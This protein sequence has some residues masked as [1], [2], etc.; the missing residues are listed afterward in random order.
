MQSA[1][2]QDS[3]TWS[4]V[5]CAAVYPSE[6][7]VVVTGITASES[8]PV[9]QHRIATGRRTRQQPSGIDD[10]FVNNTSVESSNG[11]PIGLSCSPR[12]RMTAYAARVCEYWNNV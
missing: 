9:A 2:D 10:V 5:W 6:E 8:S 7:D 1:F 4:V 3:Q 11:C 12:C